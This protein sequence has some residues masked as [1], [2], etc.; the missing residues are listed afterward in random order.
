MRF[1]AIRS[2]HHCKKKLVDRSLGRSLKDT[3]RN[4]DAS[5]HS[6]PSENPVMC[7][8]ADEKGSSNR[9]EC[10]KIVGGNSSSSLS[11]LFEAVANLTNM[12]M[13]HID[14]C[15]T[16]ARNYSTT[17][18]GHERCEGAVRVSPH[19]QTPW[20]EWHRSATHCTDNSKPPTHGMLGHGSRQ[21]MHRVDAQKWTVINCRALHVLHVHSKCYHSSQRNSNCRNCS[22]LVMALRHHGTDAN[23]KACIRQQSC[24]ETL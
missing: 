6:D 23:S 4:V 18:A 13:H 3:Q 15:A 21:A 12:R 19:L 10:H 2:G 9:K 20:K 5:W 7:K 1:T 17:D 16:S 8:I 11:S 22:D 14:G 24:L